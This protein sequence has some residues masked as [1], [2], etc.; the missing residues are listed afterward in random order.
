[1]R[2]ELQLDETLFW[3]CIDQQQFVLCNEYYCHGYDKAETRRK[4][5]GGHGTIVYVV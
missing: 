2:L 5:V 3:F 4:L 1:M